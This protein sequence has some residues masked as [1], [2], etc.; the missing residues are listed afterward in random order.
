MKKNLFILLS[1]LLLSLL[2]INATTKAPTPTYKVNEKLN[3]QKL[4]RAGI[5]AQIVNK[6]NFKECNA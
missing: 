2:F 3:L 5:E 1:F 4:T 6:F